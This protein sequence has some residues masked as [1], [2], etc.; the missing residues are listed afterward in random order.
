[1]RRVCWGR[2]AS[3]PGS[4]VVDPA[5]RTSGTGRR[6][7]HSHGRQRTPAV[8]PSPPPTAGSRAPSRTSKG[9]G[10]TPSGTG[11]RDG[12]PHTP[13]RAAQPPTPTEGTQL[14]PAW[15]HS[16]VSAAQRHARRAGSAGVSRADAFTRPAPGVRRRRRR[17]QAR[18][19]PAS[20]SAAAVFP[21]GGRRVKERPRSGNSACQGAPPFKSFGVSG[22]AP[23]QGL[24]RVGR[25]D[26]TAAGVS[27][28]PS[29]RRHTRRRAPGTGFVPKPRAPP[30]ARPVR[31]T[32]VTFPAAGRPN[33]LSRSASR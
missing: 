2:P 7:A 6:L 19:G 18:A 5:R 10:S 29:T 1:M 23:A 30:V 28:A 16:G 22:R 3:G 20:A 14:A 11:G 13:G 24:R 31:Q 12:T 27:R 15:T 32:S 4:P 9:L 25:P 33:V 8:P 21:P 17:V 26:G